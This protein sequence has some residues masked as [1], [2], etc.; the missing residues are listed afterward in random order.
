MLAF[1]PIVFLLALLTLSS[2]A[3]APDNSVFTGGRCV[4]DSAKYLQGVDWQEATKLNLRIRQDE[5]FPVYM[6]LLQ[7]RPYVLAIE[8][9]DDTSHTFR[10]MEFFRAIAVAGVRVDGGEFESAACLKGVSIPAGKVT[11]IRLVAI[12][13]GSY[14]FDDNALMFSLAMVGSAGGFITIEPPRALLDSP[15]D[16]LKLFVSKPV[17]SEPQESKPAGLFDDQQETPAPAPG[18][19][20][21]DQEQPPSQPSGG[22]FD[23]PAPEQPINGS[24]AVPVETVPEPSENLF[25]EPSLAPP[26]E[27]PEAPLVDA[28]V[29]AEPAENLFNEPSLQPQPVQPE[30]PLVDAP[31]QADP[32]E[33]LFNE[34]SLQP[35]PEQPEAP[36]VEAPLEAPVVDVAPETSPAP[37]APAPLD[38]ETDMM[39]EE[40]PIVE[41]APGIPEKE[42]NDEAEEMFV[43]EAPQIP[44]A[45]VAPMALPDDSEHLEGP[46]A[47]IFSD[48]PD[49]VNSGPGSGGAAGDDQFDGSG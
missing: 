1:R 14:E 30:V 49:V 3:Y 20:F 4:T 13:D 41:G 47:D 32:T 16:H 38:S 40:A 45:P 21:D 12:R 34:P 24:P 6:G 7:N 11:E 8:N 43:E 25:G 31:V 15:L 2:C 19:L 9:A 26:A 44:V 42:T 33:N 18:G 5:F 10:A 46:P 22:L 27:Q 23:D 17:V 35:Q 28:P 36:L 29:Q 48:P 37:A 39:M